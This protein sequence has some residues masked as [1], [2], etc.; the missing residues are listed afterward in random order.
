MAGLGRRVDQ[1]LSGVLALCL[2]QLLMR[3]ASARS[4]I[5]IRPIVWHSIAKAVWST[6][7]SRL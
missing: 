2:P 7:D 3:P 5:S 6:F 4:T 1:G